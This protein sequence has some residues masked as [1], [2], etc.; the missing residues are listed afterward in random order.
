[1]SKRLLLQ[2]VLFVSTVAPVM[3]SYAID[4]MPNHNSKVVAEVSKNGTEPTNEQ[5]SSTQKQLS[6][7]KENVTDQ[8]AASKTDEAE[9]MD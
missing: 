7:T 4:A 8:N 6:S 9:E 3:S 5:A 1:M 2:S